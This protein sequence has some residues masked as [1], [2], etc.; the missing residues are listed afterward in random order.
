MLKSEGVESV[1]IQKR[2]SL[3]NCVLID[4]FITKDEITNLTYFIKSMKN[5]LEENYSTFRDLYKTD[6]EEED[7]SSGLELYF[8]LGKTY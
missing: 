2:F 7:T 8:Y 5:Y 4:K 1:I 6:D 3:P